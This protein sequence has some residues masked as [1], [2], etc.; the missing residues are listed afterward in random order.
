MDQAFFIWCYCALVA[1]S[2]RL[3]CPDFYVTTE[4]SL[5]GKIDLSDRITSDHEVPLPIDTTLSK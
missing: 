2:I 1:D 3:P 4:L 5:K